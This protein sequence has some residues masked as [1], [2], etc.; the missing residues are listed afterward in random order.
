MRSAAAEWP[1][2]GLTAGAVSSRIGAAFMGADGWYDEIVSTKN[3]VRYQIC[4]LA[5]RMLSF[6][7]FAQLRHDYAILDE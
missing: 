4:P 2:S 6:G 1:V 7:K 3:A 5:A